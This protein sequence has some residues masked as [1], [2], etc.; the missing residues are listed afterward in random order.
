[1][2]NIS[3][4]VTLDLFQFTA[5]EEEVSGVGKRHKVLMRSYKILMK[6]S[7]TKLPR[8]E[9]EEMGPRAD[10][11]IRRTHLA[12]EDLFKSACKQVRICVIYDVIN[13]SKK[14]EKYYFTVFEL[15]KL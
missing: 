5:V 10:L 8:I 1:M 7:G 12:S 11:A 6:K 4:K 3:K 15:L 2:K 14:I 13:L 9:L